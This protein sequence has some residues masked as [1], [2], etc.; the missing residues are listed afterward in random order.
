[1][2]KLKGKKGLS[3]TCFK[4]ALELNEYILGIMR[5]IIITKTETKSKLLF[6]D[7]E[8]YNLG[9]CREGSFSESPNLLDE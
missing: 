4:V 3:S 7:L 6:S 5:D 2:K 8:V 9:T 1:M